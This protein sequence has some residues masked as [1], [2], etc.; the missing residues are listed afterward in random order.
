M[1]QHVSSCR[2]FVPISPKGGSGCL[3]D[4]QVGRQRSGHTSR[5]TALTTAMSLDTASIDAPQTV[6]SVVF[7]PPIDLRHHHLPLPHNH[8]PTTASPHGTSGQPPHLRS[9]SHE[10]PWCGF[11]SWGGLSGRR[12]FQDS[13]IPPAGHSTHRSRSCHGADGLGCCGYLVGLCCC[14]AHTRRL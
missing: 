9:L 3:P 12:A 4:V 6:G 1:R 2:G 5:L 14:R 8:T 11:A 7:P 10:H 13:D